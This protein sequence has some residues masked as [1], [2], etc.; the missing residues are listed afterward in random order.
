MFIEL[1]ML[2]PLTQIHRCSDKFTNDQI[3]AFITFVQYTRPGTVRL[4]Q[5]LEPVAKS[6]MNGEVPMTFSQT[7]LGDSTGPLTQNALAIAHNEDQQALALQWTD[8]TWVVED[9]RDVADE[10]MAEFLAFLDNH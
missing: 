8:G 2:A 3:D 6:I 5:S 9:T 1:F 10:K 4:F 7:I